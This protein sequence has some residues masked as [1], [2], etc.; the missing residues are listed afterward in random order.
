MT[1]KN[2][3]SASR[4]GDTYYTPDWAVMQ[5]LDLVLPVVLG[6]KTPRTILEPGAGDGA[7]VRRLLEQYPRAKIT[8]L[9]IDPK[10][11]PWPGCFEQYQCADFLQADY[12]APCDLVVGNPPFTL[13]LEFCLASLALSKNV[14]FLV[15]QGFLSS[16]RRSAFFRAHPPAH[17]FIL[18]KRPSFTGGQT[19]TADYCFGAWS[20]E[21]SGATQLHWLPVPTLGAKPC[22]AED[23]AGAQ[24]EDSDTSAP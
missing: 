22:P 3:K 16:A 23:S 9:D 2:I 19:D 14:V 20:S 1:A 13:A 7:F 11:G 8:A 6:G 15:R 10:A 24:G 5:C 21:F 17:V 4:P 12:L 18:T